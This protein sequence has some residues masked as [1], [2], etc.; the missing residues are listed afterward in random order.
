[1]SAQTT[2]FLSQAAP[3]K[4]RSDF[5]SEQKSAH[6]DRLFIG[7]IV[8]DNSRRGLIVG[9]RHSDFLSDWSQRTRTDFLS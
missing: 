8:C 3:R 4:D 6:T 2:D 7:A 1:M 9:W 5:I